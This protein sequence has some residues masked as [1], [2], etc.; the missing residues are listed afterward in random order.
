[1]KETIS[2]IVCALML[3]TIGYILGTL[4]IAISIY[5]ESLQYDNIGLFL[6]ILYGGYKH[7]IETYLS[8]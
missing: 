6:G 2:R 5:P 8:Y 3:G 7:E 1:M 4:I